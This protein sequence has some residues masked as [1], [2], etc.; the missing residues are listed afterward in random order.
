MLSVTV[1]TSRATYEYDG[2]GRHR[3]HALAGELHAG[4]CG[5]KVLAPFVAYGVEAGLLYPMLRPSK[6]G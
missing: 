6:T 5:D 1:G 4:L 3:S 2:G